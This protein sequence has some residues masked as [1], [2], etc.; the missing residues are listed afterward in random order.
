MPTYALYVADAIAIGVLVFGF[1]L[2]RHQRPELIVALLTVNV[3]VLA[4]ASALATS[5]IGAG[6]GLGLFGKRRS[7]VRFRQAAHCDVSG[8]RN[9]P[10]LRIV[11]SD[12]F[13]FG[14][15]PGG[16]PVGW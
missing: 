12:Y 11:G 1:F 2:P 4:V 15:G 13:C 3:G 7:S 9:S 10:N 8:H 5:T 6:L 16:R 14:V